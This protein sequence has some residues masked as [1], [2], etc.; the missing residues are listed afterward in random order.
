MTEENQGIGEILKLK[1]TVAADINIKANKVE[2]AAPNIPS[3][4]IKI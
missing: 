3:S 2:H 1:N 4:G